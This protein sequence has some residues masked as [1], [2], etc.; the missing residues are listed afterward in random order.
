[1]QKETKINSSTDF[2]T[3]NTVSTSSMQSGNSG[4]EIK[5]EEAIRNTI[6]EFMQMG[7]NLT[8]EQIRDKISKLAAESAKTEAVK[9]EDKIPVVQDALETSI[10][11]S[12]T[13]FVKMPIKNE[14]TMIDATQEEKNETPI[15]TQTSTYTKS[16][17]WTSLYTRT[18]TNNFDKKQENS[19]L[20]EK[21]NYETK[22]IDI[23]EI[24]EKADETKGERTKNRRHSFKHT[25]R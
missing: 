9:T 17:D 23:D 21:E 13:S 22:I 18:D 24:K 19:I 8:A 2:G 11:S 16:N 7:K 15:N 4:K 12:E 25:S 14:S 20:E 6:N 5:N 1:M 3:S 10:P